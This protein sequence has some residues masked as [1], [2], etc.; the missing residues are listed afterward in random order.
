MSTVA[1]ATFN[2]KVVRQFS[3]HDG[4]V[5]RRRHDGRRSHRRPADLAGAELRHSLAQLR[6][7]APAA[8]QR[9]DLRLRRLRPDGQQP[10]RRAA[11]LAS[12]AFRAASSRRSCSGAGRRSSSPRRSRCRSATPAAKEY[13]ELEWPIDILIAVVWVAYAIVFFGTIGKRKV[14]AHLRREL[15]LRRLHHRRGAAAHR[16]QRGDSG[17]LA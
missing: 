1:A 3:H 7:P 17:R 4:G 10:L 16:Q 12:R 5:G 9:G 6:A 14:R 2:Y 13:A 15:V 11:H 8:Y